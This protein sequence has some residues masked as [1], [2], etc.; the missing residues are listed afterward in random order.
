M[1]A[2]MSTAGLAGKSAPGR[3]SCSRFRNATSPIAAMATS[4]SISSRE[5]RLQIDRAVDHHGPLARQGQPGRS[6]SGPSSSDLTQNTS[7][8]SVRTC[9]LIIRSSRPILAG[10]AIARLVFGIR[11]NPALDRDVPRDCQRHIPLHLQCPACINGQRIVPLAR[12]LF[13]ITQLQRAPIPDHQRLGL[14]HALGRQDQASQA[15]CF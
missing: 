3:P 1:A 7:R 5:L 6:S 8:S 12:W 13:W 14:C 10:L 2:L 15:Q 4:A 11:E 9:R